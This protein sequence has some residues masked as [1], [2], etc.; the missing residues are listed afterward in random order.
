MRDDLSGR[1]FYEPP[2][3]RRGDVLGALVVAVHAPEG[4]DDPEGDEPDSGP[5][6]ELVLRWVD[7]PRSPSHGSAR[8]DVYWSSWPVLA[9]NPEI[10]GVLASLPTDDP[11]PEEV[12]LAL[13]GIGFRRVRM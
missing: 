10:V 1:F 7:L 12:A 11:S 6:G 4:A 13:E 8:L 2:W 3:E 9:A 5:T